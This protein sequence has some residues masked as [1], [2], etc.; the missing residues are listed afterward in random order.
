MRPIRRRPVRR[1]KMVARRI[2]D[3]EA[4]NKSGHQVVD[5]SSTSSISPLMTLSAEHG[6]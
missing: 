4:S 6:S 1:R 2:Q 5:E 3:D